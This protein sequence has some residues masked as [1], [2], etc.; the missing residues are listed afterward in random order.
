[1]NEY[2]MSVREKAGARVDRG[3]DFH[4]KGPVKTSALGFFGV[5]D[6]KS[7]VPLRL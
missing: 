5:C 2:E 6:G 1:M 7:L 4:E 3:K